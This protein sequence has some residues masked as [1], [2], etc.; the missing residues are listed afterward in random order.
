MSRYNY[1]KEFFKKIDTENK[2]Y[3]LGFLYADGSITRFYKDDKLRSMS[4]ELTLKAE[5]KGHLFKYLHDLESNVPIQERKNKIKDKVYYSNRVV[6]NYTKLCKDLIALGCTPAKSLTLT[7]PS[8]EQ[9]P[10]Q[11]IQH[12]MR[13]YFDGDGCIHYS[14]GVYFHKNKNKEYLGR[15]F[16]C[17]I[18]GTYEF[19]ESFKSVL[20]ENGISSSDI[21]QGNTGKAFELRITD[22]FNIKRFY[23]YLYQDSSVYLKRKHDIFIHAFKQYADLNA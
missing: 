6:I 12:F 11:F 2:A 16:V 14:E 3:W 8:I 9:V 23:E 4:V 15:N 13:G 22:R 1:N 7:F 17:S 20:G 19:L 5:D 21:K 18:I 10:K